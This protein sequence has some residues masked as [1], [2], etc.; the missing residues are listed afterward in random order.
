[1]NEL[2]A[3]QIASV[4][5]PWDSPNSP[6]CCVGVIENGELSYSQGFGRA[7][8]EYPIAITSATVFDIASM[9]KQ[10]TAAC[11]ALEIEAG[12]L[13][14]DDDIRHYL[15]ELHVTAQPVLIRHLLHHTSGWPDYLNL[16]E[17]NGLREADYVDDSEVMTLL[18][19]QTS[20]TFSPGERYEYCNTGYY[21]LGVIISR[22][23]GLSL[24]TY[25][26]EHIFEPLEMASTWFQ[27]DHTRIVPRRATGY[28]L[29][30][31]R[32]HTDV[33]TLDIVG[34]GAVLTCVDDLVKWDRNFYNNR[35]GNGQQALIDMMLVPGRLNDGTS[36]DYGFGLDLTPYR[37]L[38]CISHSGWYAGYRS[39]M[40]R[41]PALKTT[42]ICLAN[43]SALDPVTSCRQ[44]ADLLLRDNLP[45]TGQA[46]HQDQT[47]P[48]NLAAHSP[49]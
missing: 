20:L 39:E 41:F 27:D 18:Q 23:S 12:R 40:I 38:T 10:M 1:M 26:R 46:T 49:A 47:E 15:P 16:L 5:A 22:L 25:A 48:T 33:T 7:S 34:D 32:Y 3:Q 43:T 4:F 35:L 44:V 6:G 21:L 36:I 2:L 17:S 31:G 9:S 24:P 19:S 28:S 37:G 8:L 45:A 11:I 30:D 13:H 42:V 14:L 29:H